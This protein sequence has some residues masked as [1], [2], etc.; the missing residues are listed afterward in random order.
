MI[1]KSL[2]C[3]EKKVATVSTV[4]SVGFS[5]AHPRAPGVFE[6]AL[7]PIRRGEMV[8]TVGA[9]PAVG[10]SVTISRAKVVSQFD[11]AAALRRHR[12]VG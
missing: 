5:F 12:S 10:S 11:V 1:T 3:F 2:R 8:A 7:L 9:V 4:L 6:C